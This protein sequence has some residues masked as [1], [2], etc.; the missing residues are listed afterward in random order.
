MYTKLDYE[1]EIA[2]LGEQEQIIARK[3]INSNFESN[4]TF[5]ALNSSYIYYTKLL[6]I[7]PDESQIAL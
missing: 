3:S 6:F 1:N 7:K 4:I 2:I 5:V